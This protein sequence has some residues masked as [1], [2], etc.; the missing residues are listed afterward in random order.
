MKR[1][2]TL[3][4]ITILLATLGGN[5]TVAESP[6][7]VTSTYWF[8][9]NS[10]L[11]PVPGMVNAPLY[12]EIRN[13]GSTI[14]NFTAYIYLRSPFSY[15]YIINNSAVEEKTIISIP[16]F[17]Q[18]STLKIMQLVNISPEAKNGI[19]QSYLFAYGSTSIGGTVQNLSTTFLVPL[20]GNV[21]LFVAGSYLGSNGVYVN[22]IPGENPLPLTLIIG[23][24]GNSSKQIVTAIP[25]YGYVQVTFPVKFYS[26]V[27]NGTYTESV[28]FSYLTV[29]GTINFNFTWSNSYN[30]SVLGAYIGST[31][32]QATGG[33][34]NIPLFVEIMNTGT[35]YISNLHIFY[36]PTFPFYGSAQSIE[37]PVVAPLQ[38]LTLN[39][40]ISIYNHTSPGIYKQ[41]II[42]MAGNYTARENFN[43]FVTGYSNITVLSSYLSPSPYPPS[44][45]ARNVALNIIVANY[46]N[47]PETNVSFKY[48]PTYP[49]YGSSQL[50]NVPVLLPYQPVT[51]NFV[52]SIYENSSDDLYWQEITD[53]HD[54]KL[55]KFQV[56]IFGY[57]NIQVQ[58]YSENPPYVFTNQTFNSI[59]FSIIN[60]GNSLAYNVSVT[61]ISNLQIINKPMLI[62]VLPPHF[63][64]NYTVYYN[65]PS[66]PGIYNISLYVNNNKTV[67]QINVLKQPYV[68]VKDS[69][70][71]L[72]P[73][74]SKVQVN[75]FLKNMGPGNITMMHVIF[76]YPQVID[77]HVSSSNP[78]EGLMLNNVTLEAFNENDSYT[79]PYIVDVAD[80]ALPGQYTAK[81]V[82]VIYE[83]ISTKPILETYTFTFTI[84]TPLFSTGSNALITL[85]NLTIFILVAI[86]IALVF[87]IIKK[88]KKS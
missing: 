36:N 23:N 8:G 2:I 19:Y 21:H 68:K 30:V 47:A 20:E 51:L 13:G 4:A 31:S 49:F 78:L 81:L 34:L 1:I 46:G 26:N 24:S 29:E 54:G 25:S 9:E 3:M 75:F 15:G 87:I 33:M 12:V 35:G 70:P 63:I 10:T 42:F 64:F 79:I 6:I 58:G 86:I 88:R 7:V 74:E 43:I 69:F 5:F 80:N 32:F 76:L 82:M 48:T 57:S 55:L 61:T 84:S 45:G 53:I 22:P 59:T 14:Y 37:I 18:G 52:V 66:K 40:L 11:L 44:P 27:K 72:V 28:N 85:S 50:F 16:Q 67:V 39:F 65:T 73:G 71:S 41:E 38:Q 17:A 60:S 77:L 62:A 56:G 83:N